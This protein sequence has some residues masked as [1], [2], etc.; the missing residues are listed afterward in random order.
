MLCHDDLWP[1]N[2]VFR[3]GHAA[4]LINDPRGTG[5]TPSASPPPTR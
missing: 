1:D 2:V 5:L 3:D 4:A